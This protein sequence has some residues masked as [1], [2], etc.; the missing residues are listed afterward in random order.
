MIVDGKTI[1]ICGVGAGLG[2]ETAEAALRDGA[3][4][5][6]GARTESQL[7]AIAKE[8]DPSGERVAWKATDITNDEQNESLAQLA[9]D[10][11]GQLDGLV[12]VAA[13]DTAFGGLEQGD[14]DDFARTYE[15]N[16]VG[17]TRIVKS[18]APHL[19]R[20]GGGSVVLIGAQASFKPSAEAPQMAYGASKAALQSA[21]YYMAT[22]LGRDRIRVNMVV[23]GWMWGDPAEGFVNMQAKE[24]GVSTEDVLSGIT[25]KMV[26]PQMPEDGDVAEAALFFCS[27]RSRYITGQY[28]MVNSGEVM[29]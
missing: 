14:I 27:D 16:V 4:V 9:V 20:A 28:L 18:V 7:Q 25:S 8:I 3:N 23:P 15:V 29:M 11:F 2:R 17:S 21:M 22:E 13:Y 12:Q 26:L 5:V 6:L 24:L 10:R 1:L 19:K